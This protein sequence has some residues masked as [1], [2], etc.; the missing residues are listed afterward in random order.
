M[1]SEI[2]KQGAHEEKGEM[3]FMVCIEKFDD[4]Y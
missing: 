4:V 1:S 2:L 3:A